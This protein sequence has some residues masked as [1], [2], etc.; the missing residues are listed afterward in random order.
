MARTV[1]LILDPSFGA[2]LGP[3]AFH[4]PVWIVDT[5]PNRTAAQEAWRSADEWPHISVTMFRSLGGHAK[6]KDWAG[7]LY[8]IALQQPFDTVDV[9]G[10]EI[11][12]SARGA[13]TD[14]GFTHVE[15]TA[16]GVRMKRKRRHRHNPAAALSPEKAF[17]ISAHGRRQRRTCPLAITTTGADAFRL[18][19]LQSRRPI[20][21]RFLSW[22]Q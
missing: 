5:P 3:L 8:Q 14:A 16:N 18:R 15:P 12:P 21:N 1:A 2:Q 9:I 10:G 17:G 20:P 6:K 19:V 22:T 4:T 7:L 13:L 11:T